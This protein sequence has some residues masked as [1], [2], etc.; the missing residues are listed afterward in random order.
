MARCTLESPRATKAAFTFAWDDQLVLQ[1]NAQPPLDLGT[2]PYLRAR[3]IK[4][5]L[6]RG[7]NVVAVRLSNREGLTRGAWAFSFRCKTAQGEVL[8]PQAEGQPSR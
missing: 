7:K 5:P 4:V 2:Q 6:A 8:R 1:V 3:T